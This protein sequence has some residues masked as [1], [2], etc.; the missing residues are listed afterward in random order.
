MKDCMA[1]EVYIK[2]GRKFHKLISRETDTSN[3]ASGTFPYVVPAH[4]MAQVPIFLY[5]G[6]GNDPARYIQLAGK[7]IDL[8]FPVDKG[9]TINLD[10]RMDANKKIYIDIVGHDGSVSIEEDMRLSETE[11]VQDPIHKLKI[12][13]NMYER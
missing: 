12:N 10:W 4:G 6:L 1:D 5:Y 3:G 9:E 11:L 2:V 7:F 13:G 8:K